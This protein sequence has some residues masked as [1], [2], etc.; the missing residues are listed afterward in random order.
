MNRDGDKEKGKDEW[1][2]VYETHEIP[3]TPIDKL[4]KLLF[5]AMTVAVFL[6][7]LPSILGT[8]YAEMFEGIRKIF[9]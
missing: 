1:Q 4:W 9:G 3:L 7:Y 5:R 6:Y 2:E 8:S